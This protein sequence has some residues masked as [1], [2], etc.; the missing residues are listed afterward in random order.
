MNSQKKE[1]REIIMLAHVHEHSHEERARVTAVY[2][3]W[4][5]SVQRSVRMSYHVYVR[6]TL[7]GILFLASHAS[8]LC[9]ST[10]TAV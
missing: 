1:V 4:K 2:D 5:A 6:R 7:V 9:W 3:V 8:H 10:S